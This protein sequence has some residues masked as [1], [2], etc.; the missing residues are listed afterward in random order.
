V[1]IIRCYHKIVKKDQEFRKEI[2]F[3][4]SP[5]LCIKLY[6]KKNN[7]L[8]DVIFYYNKN[9]LITNQIEYEMEMTI[10]DYTNKSISI[11]KLTKGKAERT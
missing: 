5:F 11:I 10:R 4:P 8:I 3:F 9:Q 1:T 7:H 2:I 6:V